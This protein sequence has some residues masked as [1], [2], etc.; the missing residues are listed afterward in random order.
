MRIL[1]GLKT[2]EKFS[3]I[4][5]EELVNSGKL[6]ISNDKRDVFMMGGLGN[7]IN[8]FFFHYMIR[9]FIIGKVLHKDLKFK[10]PFPGH[11]GPDNV[12]G[13]FFKDF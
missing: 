8:L 2:K 12:L 9:Y 3:A 13:A 10:N 7:G 1:D 6:L 11:I 4:S 5:L